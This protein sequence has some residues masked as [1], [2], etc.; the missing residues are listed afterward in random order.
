MSIPLSDEFGEVQYT[1]ISK[2]FARPYAYTSLKGI[3]FDVN[4]SFPIDKHTSEA[5]EWLCAICQ[6]LSPSSMLRL[7][8]LF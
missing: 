7:V 3:C 8:Y 2:I 4:I 5:E 6:T 1:L